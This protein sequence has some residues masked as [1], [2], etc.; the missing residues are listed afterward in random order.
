MRITEDMIHGMGGKESD[1]YAMFLSYVGA[2]FLSLRGPENAR[3]LLS[4]VR[5]LENSKIPDISENQSLADSISGMR[6]RLKLDLT[7]SE[8]ITYIEDLMED[9]VSNT[10]WLAVDAMHHLGKQF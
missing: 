10:M 7:E 6:S 9:S 5:L 2:A 3:V 1:N 8:S 4:M